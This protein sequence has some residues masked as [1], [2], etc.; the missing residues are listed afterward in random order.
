MSS[1]LAGAA[2]LVKEDMQRRAKKEEYAKDP[3]LWA[4]D[5]LGVHLWSKQREIVY[6]V[7]DNVRTAVRSSNGIGKTES[8]AVLTLW[9]LYVHLEEDP[10][11]TLVVV[12]AQ[13][14]PQIKTNVFAALKRLR[15]IAEDNG[16]EF[17]GRINDSG[18]TAAWKLDDGT[19]IVIGRRPPDNQVVT[20]F[21]GIHRLHTLV[22][23]DE[24]GGVP[25]ELVDLAERITSGGEPRI[26]AIGNPDRIG[27]E[28]HLMFG[29]DSDW[30]QVHISTYDTPNLT[31]EEVPKALSKKLP[32]KAWAERQ[33]KKYGENDPRYQISVLGEFPDAD[34]QIF[35]PQTLI[36]KGLRTEIP[37]DH[38]FPVRL[39]VDLARMGDDSSVVYSF[40][41]GRLRKVSEWSK[42]TAVESANRIH[43]VALEK[44]ATI[45]Q[46]DAGGLGGPIIDN[47]V[48]FEPRP[49][50]II[51]MD[52]S[53]KSSDPR[54]WMN[55]RAE[56]YDN[57]RDLLFSE[58]MDLDPDD[59]NLLENMRDINFE[60]VDGKGHIKIE[61][62]K[63]LKSRTG[64]SPDYLDAA[65]YAAF[66]KDKV[67]EEPPARQTM[68]EDAADILDE[69]PAYLELLVKYYD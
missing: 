21:Q 34:D 36:E 20:S 35:F 40:Q 44:G 13:S 62:K 39:G 18:N 2:K 16:F 30:Y 6:S 55:S 66:D 51:S 42:A 5:A 37:E 47:L 7:R 11:E 17:P 67:P 14:F 38:D 29:K 65:I 22:I 23:I 60:V 48:T 58:Q 59:E 45:V 12:T 46:I 32:S 31:G 54:R 69:M 4:K 49:Y 56:W 3:V 26:L 25:R 8:A 63:D 10:K 28:F 41:N 9:Y 1:I 50:T 52:G 43:Q 27:S 64:K 33:R 19:E 15:K 68:Y 57:F 61:S 53:H 24:A